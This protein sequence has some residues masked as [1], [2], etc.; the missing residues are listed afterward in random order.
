MRKK[1]DLLFYVPAS[2]VLPRPEM[3]V[4]L[5]WNYDDGIVVFKGKLSKQYLCL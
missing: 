5:V 3:F 2:Y 1:Y 4:Y